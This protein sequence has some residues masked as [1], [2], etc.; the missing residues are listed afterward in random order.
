MM[1]PTRGGQGLAPMLRF[2]VLTALFLVGIWLIYTIRDTLLPF[3]IAFFLSYVLAPLVD[4]LESRG[5]NRIAGVLVIYAGVIGIFA[6]LMFLVVPVLFDG[7]QDMKQRVAGDVGHWSCEISNRG[8]ED[9]T[10]EAFKSP[11]TEFVLAT[12]TLPVNLEPGAQEVLDV[13]FLPSSKD[14]VSRFVELVTRSGETRRV[15]RVRLVGNGNG[16]SIEE[17]MGRGAQIGSATVS[18]TVH[19]FGKVVPGYLNTVRAQIAVLEPELKATLP[20]LADVDISGIIG[21]RIR[22]VGTDLLNK[23]PALVGSLISGIT[24][25][26]IVPIVGLFFLG[27]GRAIKRAFI[28]MV[29]NPY[30]EMVLNLI[31]R[32]D[33]QLGGYIR[34]L[35][36]SVTLISLLSI[37]GL[38]L[39]GL[40]DY[41]V[42]GTIAGLANVIPYLGPII[43]IVAGVFAAIMQHSSL[44]VG[45]WLPVVAVFATVQI[46]DNVF[47]APVV[48]ARSVNLHPL[49]VIFVVLVGNQLLGA[50][51]MLLA[52]P[53]TAVAKVAIQTLHEGL[54]SYSTS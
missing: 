51:G 2:L 39:I 47:V 6:L 24:L 8:T 41:L 49:V 32:I 12:P 43:G 7:L 17:G 29:P 37:S 3:A 44:E 20:M 19:H 50:V 23:T 28:Q 31:H 54:R 48:V 21:K 14:S 15:L 1:E 35:V 9:L 22:G 34:G 5:V 11:S 33:M 26:V 30:F 42:V 10:L 27:E 38:R 18:D 46:F 25:L 4:R 36:L 40:H 13:E 52:V 16:D 45:V 53:V